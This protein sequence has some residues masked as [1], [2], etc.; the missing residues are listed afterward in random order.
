MSRQFFLI[1]SDDVRGSIYT[2]EG[3]G[4]IYARR[5]W[6]ILA[7]LFCMHSDEVSVRGCTDAF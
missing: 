4:V 5:T 2:F 3:A 6:S 1:R 7:P